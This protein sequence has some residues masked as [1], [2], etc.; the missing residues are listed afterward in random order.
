MSPAKC[1]IFPKNRQRWSPDL[2]PGT[3][4]VHALRRLAAFLMWCAQTK[5]SWARTKSAADARVEAHAR[6]SLIGPRDFFL[7]GRRRLRFPHEPRRFSND[8]FWID[9]NFATS[10]LISFRI[11]EKVF[12]N[13]LANLLAW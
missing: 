12:K 5:R 6:S 9:E 1:G 13:G 7:R 3:S 10:R 2:R 8:E 4:K 11:R